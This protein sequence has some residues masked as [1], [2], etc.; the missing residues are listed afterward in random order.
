MQNNRPLA[1]SRE[2]G[3]GKREKVNFYRNP[4]PPFMSALPFAKETFA[5]GLLIGHRL[6]PIPSGNDLFGLL[7]SLSCL[8]IAF[9]VFVQG[10]SG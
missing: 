9:T 5:R 10:C 7:L 8:A 2:R 6:R 1:R 4:I 3:K